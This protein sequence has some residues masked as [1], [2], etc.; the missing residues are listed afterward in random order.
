MVSLIIL[1]VQVRLRTDLSSHLP[2]MWHKS[3]GCWIRAKPSCLHALL[4][5][6]C[7][8]VLA[9]VSSVDTSVV[10]DQHHDRQAVPAWIEGEWVQLNEQLASEEGYE[11]DKQ[12]KR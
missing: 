2:R 9:S 7:Q 8:C 3:G 5:C 12:G 10:H 4:C 6:S 1:V 11:R